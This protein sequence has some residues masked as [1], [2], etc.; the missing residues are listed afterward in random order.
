VQIVGGIGSF[1][2]AWGTHLVFSHPIAGA[3]GSYDL[4]EGGSVTLTGAAESPLNRPVVAYEWDFNYD[5]A[6]FDVDGTGP[7][8]SFS[9]ANI[10]GPA[11]R[12]I[13]LRVRDS[14]GEV[15]DVTSAQVNIID[16]PPAI[17]SAQLQAPTR[18]AVNFSEDVSL[19][20][21][22]FAVIDRQ[23]GSAG[24]VPDFTYDP[25]TKRATL[26]WAQP[27]PD[28]DYRLTVWSSGVRD[29]QGQSPPADYSVDFFVLGGDANHDRAV[30]FLDLAKLAQNYNTGGSGKTYGDGDFNGDG[31]VDFLDLSILAQRYNT[32]LPAPNASAT[33][34]A[35]STSFAVDWAAATANITVPKTPSQLSP[36]KAKPQ[37]V[38]SVTPVV[39]PVKPKTSVHR[40]K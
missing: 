14:A 17:V 2:A 5:F 36:K 37:P 1:L 19:S 4:L 7:S 8:P 20:P 10:G 11:S 15:S 24:P 22:C 34:I 9:A 39:K 33:P 25:A 12:L 35:S 13:G 32:S 38:F 29:D 26:G 21:S 30:D 18:A 28:G 31:N 3:G 23:T 6:S 27:L 16:P 40:R